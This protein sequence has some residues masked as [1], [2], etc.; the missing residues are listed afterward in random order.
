LVL[1]VLATGGIVLTI[2]GRWLG[3]VALLFGP[4]AAVIGL[5][6]GLVANRLVVVHGGDRYET[7]AD[8][9]RAA[10]GER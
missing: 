7:V 4:V 2:G 1:W 5:V 10:A 9:C 3:G 8:W 6:G